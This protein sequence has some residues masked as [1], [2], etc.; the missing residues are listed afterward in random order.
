MSVETKEIFD[1]PV[2]RT[3]LYAEINGKLIK[4]DRDGIVRLDKE[5]LIGYISA[6]DITKLKDGKLIQ[7]KRKYYQIVTHNE[8][9]TEARKAIH[10][11]GF[12]PTEKTVMLNNGGK[13]FHE[14]NFPKE[15]IE[16]LPG[17]FVSMRLTLKNS[18]DLSNLCGWELGGLR[19][20]CTNGLMAFRRAF[21]ELK[22]HSGAFNIDDTMKSLTTAI[23]A[24]RGD[25]KELYS[26]FAH[27]PV[28]EGVGTSLIQEL[29]DSDKLP[30]KYG[31]A[32][33]TVWETPERINSIIPEEGS[34]NTYKTI[35]DTIAFD[36]A[37]TLW[38]LYNAFTLI[39]THYIASV[40]RRMVIHDF[41][42]KRIMR[43]YNKGD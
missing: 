35:M 24:F 39:L 3:P 16:V 14:F 4:S 18:Y 22:K 21:Y 15:T 38:T 28:T 10:N 6:E 33:K 42:Q 17:D 30:V 12:N 11:L 31:E 19:L 41:I 25:V 23:S 29:I 36:K 43:F 7:K 1:F 2:K 27:I 32:V 26:D 37:K 40:E 5:E 13:L 9:V 34:L 20:V 8:M